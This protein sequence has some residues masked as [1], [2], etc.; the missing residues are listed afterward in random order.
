[1]SGL[2]YSSCRAW[3]VLQCLNGPGKSPTDLDQARRPYGKS[4]LPKGDLINLTCGQNRNSTQEPSYYR[5]HD[6]WPLSSQLYGSELCKGPFTMER[7]WMSHW[8]DGSARLSNGSSGFFAL[9]SSCVAVTAWSYPSMLKMRSTTAN[10]L[11]PTGARILMKT[12][13]S[14]LSFP[15]MSVSWTFLATWVS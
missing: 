6:V 10:T 4:S 11:D 7:T 1:M 3:W 12:G 13:A 9:L 8:Q 14:L 15:I 2:Y 5:S